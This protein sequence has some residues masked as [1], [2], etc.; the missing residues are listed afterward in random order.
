MN[1]WDD[2]RCITKNRSEK[3]ISMGTV[4]KLMG[5]I[6]ICF[7][8][9]LFMTDVTKA[10]AQEIEKTFPITFSNQRYYSCNG[11]TGDIHEVIEVTSTLEVNAKLSLMEY[12]NGEWKIRKNYPVVPGTSKIEITYSEKYYADQT[13]RQHV[14][15]WKLSS[16][17]SK[18][19]IQL[20]D[21]INTITEIVYDGAYVAPKGM[22][23]PD[24]SENKEFDGSYDLKKGVMGLKVTKVQKK[25]G[26]TGKGTYG[27]YNNATANAV[28]KQQKKY[29]FE[30]TGVVDY[31][32]WKKMGFSKDD[33][34][35]LGAYVHPLEVT[36]G[37]TADELVKAFLDTANSYLKTN[38]IVGAAGQVG[39]GVDCSGLVLQCLYSIGIFPDCVDV[40]THSTTYE[41]GSYEMWKDDRFVEIK[42][43]ELMPGDLVFYDQ[44]GGSSDPDARPIDHIAIYIGNNKC[45]QAFQGVEIKNIT[46]SANYKTVGYK[47]VIWH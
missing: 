21:D 2:R 16:V 10:K 42:K 17:S 43:S 14:T 40:I 25:L 19:K 44:V 37:A 33:W 13:K 30:E 23:Q 11:L 47:R 34:N 28:K 4:K 26:L 29:G 20:N 24:Y 9:V 8:A 41:Y 12:V 36:E 6:G 1:I 35:N 7:L 32:L 46:L 27:Y 15:I 31:K 18:K 22:Y 45:I 39:T 3:G 38:Y 5:T